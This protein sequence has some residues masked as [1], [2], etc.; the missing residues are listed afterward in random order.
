MG[1]LVRISSGGSAGSV[2]ILAD[3]CFRKVRNLSQKRLRKGFR[4]VF[5]K[6][7]MKVAKCWYENPAEQRRL[8]KEQ[9]VMKL[10]HPQFTL[11]MGEDRLPFAREGTLFW[12][13]K[14]RTNFGSVYNVAVVYPKNY[15]YGE[16]RAYVMEFL[17]KKSKKHM[18]MDGHLCLYSN[19]HDGQRSQGVGK[20]TTAP[21]VVAWAAAWLN[22]WEVHARTGRWPGRE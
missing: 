13:G 20:E 7:E 9:D 21:T 18:Y 19:D 14:L 12:A 10:K 16:I 17:K 4:C 11:M 6:G 3:G 5:G 22:A 1:C 8:R 15:P 2:L